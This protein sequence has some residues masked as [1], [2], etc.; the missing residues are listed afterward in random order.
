MFKNMDRFRDTGLLILRL[1]LGFMFLYHGWPKLAG[2]PDMWEKLGGA[3]G[4]VGV[5][6]TP[7]LWGFMAA[8]AE[9]AGAIMLILGLF[10]RPACFLLAFT[11][12]IATMMH[13][14][15]G[16][17][18]QAA[19]HSIEDGVVFLGLFLIGPGKYGFGGRHERK[20]KPKQNKRGK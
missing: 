9:F 7:I 12:F 10:F 2:G 8:V 14:K 1:G 16:Q 19:S 15:A 11:M 3:M 4:S 17:G 18:L 5:T 13:L 6:F 20:A